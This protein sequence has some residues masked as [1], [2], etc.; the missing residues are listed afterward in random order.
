MAALSVDLLQVLRLSIDLIHGTR[1]AV[2]VLLVLRVLG[3]RIVARA[4]QAVFVRVRF[5]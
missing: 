4:Y 1:Q 2:L 5:A 3:V